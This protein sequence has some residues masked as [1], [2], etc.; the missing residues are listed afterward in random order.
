MLIYSLFCFQE[1]KLATSS[2]PIDNTVKI[3]GFKVQILTGRLY[4]LTTFLYC[5][6]NINGRSRCK[7]S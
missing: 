1:V 5:V 2:F 4:L 7:L 6:K 3:T